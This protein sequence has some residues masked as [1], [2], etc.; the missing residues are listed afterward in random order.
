MVYLM[1]TTIFF[2]FTIIKFIYKTFLYF[3]HLF[4]FFI[5]CII[6]KLF[7]RKTTLY[8][9]KKK[10]LSTLPHYV[11]SRSSI[12]YIKNKINTFFKKIKKSTSYIVISNNITFTKKLLVT[13]YNKLIFLCGWL[14]YYNLNYSSYSNI[15]FHQYYQFFKLFNNNNVY[16]NK[17]INNINWNIEYLTWLSIFKF[18]IKNYNFD[19]TKFYN[20][21][22]VI[23]F[24]KNKLDKSKKTS[25]ITKLYNINNFFDYINNI[26]NYDKLKIYYNKIKFSKN[27]YKNKY[28]YIK[29]K[30]INHININTKLKT[31][32]KS[33]YIIN[34]STT[35]II[36]YVNK[37][38]LNNLNILFLRKNKIFN[39]GR[40]SRNRQTY[41][42]GVYWCLYINIIAIIAF[43]FW[44]YKFTINFGYYWWFI[45][46]FFF[47]IFL[48]RSLKYKF[49]NFNFIIL[50]FIYFIKWLNFIIY[51][52]TENTLNIYSNLYKK[53]YYIYF[54]N[55]IKN[56]HFFK[57]F[58]NNI[59]FI[60]INNY[61]YTNTIFDNKFIIKNIIFFDNNKKYYKL[62]K[63]KL[64]QIYNKITKI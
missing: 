50:E 30:S 32:L 59:K 11:N 27:K 44:F 20:I 15:K 34:F 24:F 60:Y 13:Y 10:I 33:N 62:S 29:N 17:L 39:K 18:Y 8:I 61:I 6:F 40:Y 41:R 38:W 14:F 37:N 36:K 25:N 2:F 26:I 56:N 58:K 7:K 16:I 22:T 45:Y 51:S 47:T 35:N 54:F 55:I 12:N 5:E 1:G 43:Y 3:I 48:S 49:Y 21:I 52:I 42:T 46:F 23:I 9:Y 64:N 31:Y 57:I 28:K 4:F 63:D 53:Y 19:N